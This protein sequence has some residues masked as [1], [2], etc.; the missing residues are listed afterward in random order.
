MTDYPKWSD[1]SE[2]TLTTIKTAVR[3]QCTRAAGVTTTAS[4]DAEIEGIFAAALLPYI[5]AGCRC[6]FDVEDD[7]VQVVGIVG[8]GT[9]YLPDISA[10]LRNGGTGFVP[11]YGRT[12]ASD[13]EN[14]SGTEQVALSG[15]TETTVEGKITIG[16]PDIRAATVGHVT[17]SDI[18]AAEKFRFDAQAEKSLFLLFD[19]WIKRA[20]VFEDL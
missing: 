20:T 13:T 4:Q 3:Q 5:G 17:A 8:L 11:V 15:N 16:A 7:S 19:K 9:P 12:T 14:L 18:D 10:I 2:T 6:Y 1:F